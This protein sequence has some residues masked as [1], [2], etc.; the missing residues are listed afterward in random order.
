MKI[1]IYFLFLIYSCAFAQPYTLQWQKTFGGAGEE[2]AGSMVALP[3]HEIVICGSANSVTGDISNSLGWDDVWLVAIDTNSNILWDKSFGSTTD[4]EYGLVLCADTLNGLV[5]GAR[6]SANAGQV[7]GIHGSPGHYDWW[8]AGVDSLHN[9]LWQRCLGGSDDEYELYSIEKSK[10]GT[11]LLSGD[12]YSIDGDV[13]GNNGGHRGWMVCYNKDSGIVFQN[14]SDFGTG[15]EIAN[16]KL[17]VDSCY[18]SIGTVENRP[19]CLIG[20]MDMA[21]CKYNSNG[22]K[23]WEYCL[24]GTLI[25]GGTDFVENPDGTMWLVGGTYSNDVDVSGNNG[26]S[27][28]W[29]V[30]I[31]TLGNVLHQN[32]FGGLA[33]DYAEK[34][35]KS[36]DGG[37]IIVGYTNSTELNGFPNNLHGYTDALIIKTDSLGN[38]L[39]GKCFGGSQNDLANSVVENPDGSIYVAGTT[40]S[41]DGDVTFNHG[42]SDYWMFKLVPSSS[43]ILE[44]KGELNNFT[45]T[46][47]SISKKW[48]IQYSSISLNNVT[49]TI[50]DLSGR[51]IK[52][53]DHQSQIGMNIFELDNNGNPNGVYIIEL[54]S[55]QSKLRGKLISLN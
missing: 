30:K 12:T 14:L 17:G 34:I 49:I 46:I 54:N 39:W 27:D 28:I 23:L 18:F 15:S 8:V 41:S 9:L 42:L 24:G 32:C 3:N 36:S 10:Y 22:I 52:S 50:Y 47:N 13:N 55:K 45:V 7:S 19:N 53:V 26:F 1:F 6:V 21:F 35:T 48:I 25:D 16:T 40:E 43:S 51:K 2:I 20:G 37:L 11:Y 38:L 31:D 33:T 44:T 29:L 5:F 4:Y